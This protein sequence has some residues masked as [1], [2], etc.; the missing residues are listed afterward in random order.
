MFCNKCGN[1]VEE[2]TVFC[3]SC[4]N[5]IVTEEVKPVAIPEAPI[6]QPVKNKSNKFLKILLLIVG[7]GFITALTFLLINLFSNNK[8]GSSN[9]ILKDTTWIAGD[10]SEMVFGDDRLYWYRDEGVHDDNYYTGTYKFYMGS[11]ALEFLTDDLSSY[12]VT[13]EEL[14]GL[15]DRNSKYDESNTII[16][17]GKSCDNKHKK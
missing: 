9:N 1:K 7:I 12:G 11:D 16:N 4:G 2:G 15:F 5:Q 13:K 8:G 6:T 14:E 17:W 3:T 10:E